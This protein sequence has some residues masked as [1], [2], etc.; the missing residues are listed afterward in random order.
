MH[1]VKSYGEKHTLKGNS[2]VDNIMKLSWV[3]FFFLENYSQVQELYHWQ[4]HHFN[5]YTE[6]GGLHV[7]KEMNKKGRGSFL[8]SS[9]RKEE[10]AVWAEQ[11]TRT[12]PQSPP[13]LSWATPE[14]IA[15]HPV[16]TALSKRTVLWPNTVRQMV[17]PPPKAEP[18]TPILIIL[19]DLY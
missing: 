17:D 14:V 6:V 19:T 7:Y 13:A 10:K 4:S 8:V 2:R 11:Q 1:E 18:R 16:T 5:I 15:V 9:Q 3:W 12:A